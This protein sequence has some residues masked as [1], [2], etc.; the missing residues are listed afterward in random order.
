MQ[1]VW[2]GHLAD[3]ASI[4]RPQCLNISSRLPANSIQLLL[5]VGLREPCLYLLG[6]FTK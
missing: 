1:R 4:R 5:I 6:N 3:Q 2:G